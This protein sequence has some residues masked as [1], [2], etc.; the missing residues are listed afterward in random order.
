MKKDYIK[1]KHWHTRSCRLEPNGE[2]FYWPTGRMYWGNYAGNDLGAGHHGQHHYWVEMQ[3]NDPNCGY[4][5]VIK[6]DALSQLLT[7]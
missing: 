4:I 3:C 2:F 6:A 7:L 1:I 5:A